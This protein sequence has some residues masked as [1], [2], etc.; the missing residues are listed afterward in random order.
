MPRIRNRERLHHALD[1]ALFSRCIAKM[2]GV[3]AVLFAL[4]VPRVAQAAPYVYAGTQATSIVHREHFLGAGSH[5]IRTS[6]LTAGCNPYMHVVRLATRLEVGHNDDAAGLGL[7]SQVTFNVPAGQQGDYL[8]IVR[9]SSGA[10][11]RGNVLVDGVTTDTQSFFGGTAIN[12]NAAVTGT[13]TYETVMTFQ[14]A[15]D[16]YLVGLNSS[17]AVVAFDDDTG[18][19]NAS[20]FVS[21]TTTK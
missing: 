20:R 12:V 9:N 4:M 21:A 7:N 2:W 10:P 13:I 8:V 15:T 18:V 1:V 6:N 14:G 5:T 3:M 16:T 11:G 19:G 17:G